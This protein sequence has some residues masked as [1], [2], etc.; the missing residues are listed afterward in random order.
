[1]PQRF[2]KAGFIPVGS[3]TLSLANSTALGLN[4]TNVQ[5]SAFHI[6]VETQHGR[7]GF[8]STTPALTTGVLLEK[9]TNHW[10]ESITTPASLLFQR[11]TGTCTINIQAYKRPG[12]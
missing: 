9:D 5:A 1:M 7:Y 4:S 3:E 11:T 10:L 2:A 12:E 6:S 8:N